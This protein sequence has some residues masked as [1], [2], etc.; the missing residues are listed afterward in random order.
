MSPGQ[1][2][3]Q[4]VKWK[5]CMHPAA[6]MP[7]ARPR[8]ST[9]RHLLLVGL[10]HTSRD[11]QT[12]LHI[13]ALCMCPSEGGDCKR[14][15][16]GHLLLKGKLLSLMVLQMTSAS[17]CTPL[18]PVGALQGQALA[19]L[20]IQKPWNHGAPQPVPSHSNSELPF[21]PTL[22]CH[23]HAEVNPTPEQW[24]GYKLKSRVKITWSEETASEMLSLPS[25]Q[26]HILHPPELFIKM[27][28]GFPFLPPEMEALRLWPAGQQLQSVGTSSGTCKTP[29]DRVLIAA[30][31][32]HSSMA[33]L[34]S[35]GSGAMVLS[36]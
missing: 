18:R 36:Q 31:Q 13:S 32:K 22:F 15:F 27:P 24:V 19:Q 21:P 33:P 16:P 12:P 10:S 14:A 4:P 11:F 2:V 34:T 28:F 17:I 6:A 35:R 8:G 5:W 29:R 9:S 25:A 3:P 23:L 1:E 7:M 30:Y 20:G 26:Q